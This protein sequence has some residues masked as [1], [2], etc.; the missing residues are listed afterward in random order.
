MLYC[1]FISRVGKENQSSM[2]WWK[3]VNGTHNFIVSRVRGFWSCSCFPSTDLIRIRQK[4]KF[5]VCTWGRAIWEALKNKTVIN[6]NVHVLA[7]KPNKIWTLSRHRN[8]SYL[9]SLG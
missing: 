9:Y 6:M 2:K 3:K 5:S 7:T 1:S 4:I 8:M